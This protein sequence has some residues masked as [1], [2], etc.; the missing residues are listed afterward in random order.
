VVFASD[1]EIVSLLLL[2][3]SLSAIWYCGNNR[4]R[5]DQT[6]RGITWAQRALSAPRCFASH[7]VAELQ[8]GIDMVL[9]AA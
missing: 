9:F 4:I 2:A 3:C 5:D 1:R 7:A 6:C 8:A